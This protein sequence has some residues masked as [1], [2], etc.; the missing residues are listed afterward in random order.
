MIFQ[1]TMSRAF[2]T[3]MQRPDS[4]GGGGISGAGGGGSF[5]GF[6]GGGFG[7]GGFGSR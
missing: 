1:R 4:K 2:T 3:A 6:G 5:G 7:G